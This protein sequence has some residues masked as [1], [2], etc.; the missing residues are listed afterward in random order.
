M[1]P[2]P[3]PVTAALFLS[4]AS[5]SATTAAAQPCLPPPGFKDAPHPT[6]APPDQLVSHTEEIVIARPFAVVSAAMKKPLEKTIVRSDSLPG[7]AGDHM[8]TPGIYGAPGSRRI[9]CLTDGTSTEEESLAQHNT[10][11]SSHFRYIVWNYT[12]PKARPIAYGIGDFQTVQLDP[13]HTRITWAYTFKL[14]DDVFPGELGAPGRWLFRVAFLER[15]Y[16]AMMSGVLRGY[17]QTAE[18]LSASAVP[19]SH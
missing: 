6:I 1:R 9:V 13:T 4:L 11:T 7:V 18:E 10:P 3:S 15:D 12:T 16:A 14:K 8:L 5:L 2:T 19:A 17:Q